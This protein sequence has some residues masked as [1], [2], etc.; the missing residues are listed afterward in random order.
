MIS[1]KRSA[2]RPG[3]IKYLKLDM[4]FNLSEMTLGSAGPSYL[5]QLRPMRVDDAVYEIRNTQPQ[6]P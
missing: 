2:L 1:S 6:K 5:I 4:R 3:E